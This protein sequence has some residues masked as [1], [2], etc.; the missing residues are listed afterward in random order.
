M[1]G[2]TTWYSKDIKDVPFALQDVSFFFLFLDKFLLI[3]ISG[4]AAWW[5]GL[6][7]AVPANLS[8]T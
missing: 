2:V 7:G 4:W 6:I 1:E 8:E 5:L 3:T